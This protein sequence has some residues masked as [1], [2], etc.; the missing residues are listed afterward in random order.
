M[1]RFTQNQ[2]EQILTIVGDSVNEATVAEAIGQLAQGQDPVPDIVNVDP[3]ELA[4]ALQ[5][6]LDNA[7]IADSFSDEEKEAIESAVQA[8]NKP[9]EIDPALARVIVLA[10]EFLPGVSL[11]GGLE[12]IR[13]FLDGKNG[14]ERAAEAD[15]VLATARAGATVPAPTYITAAEVATLQSAVAAVNSEVGTSRFPVG[16]LK[17]VEQLMLVNGAKPNDVRRM[18]RGL[19]PQ[20]AAQV[21]LA[22][23]SFDGLVSAIQALSR[24]KEARAIDVLQLR[25]VEFEQV[26]AAFAKPVPAPVPFV[27]TPEIVRVL[28]EAADT[29]ADIKE[30]DA[31]EAVPKE[32]KAKYFTVVKTFAKK[33]ETAVKPAAHYGISDADRTLIIEVCRPRYPVKTTGPVTWELFQR[34]YAAAGLNDDKT[35]LSDGIDPVK[36]KAAKAMIGHYRM[37][38]RVIKGPLEYGLQDDVP[39]YDQYVTWLRRIGVAERLPMPE[40]PRKRG[41]MDKLVEIKFAGIPLF[42]FVIAAFLVFC[43]WVALRR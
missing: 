27:L 8:S 38:A 41:M 20:E 42:N 24:G 29:E 36:F 12:P 33:G 6:G 43:L 31:L 19:F 34:I 9:V 25:A 4:E 37:V 22:T 15:V 13:T 18:L 1:K 40:K 2:I 11:A 7:D 35:D 14:E 5:A 3:A 17:R 32:L 30:M 26:K 21:V 23:G 39:T 10:T 28:C 16:F